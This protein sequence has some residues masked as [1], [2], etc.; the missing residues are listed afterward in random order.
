MMSLK[1]SVLLGAAAVA[2]VVGASRTQAFA[3][4]RDTRAQQ[5]WNGEW[6]AGIQQEPI[7][8]TVSGDAVVVAAYMALWVIL[9][10]YVL[11]LS[12]QLRAIRRDT[13]ELK[14]RIGEGG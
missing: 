5:A 11:R 3:E 7:R 9:L 4:P 2:C 8:E 12:M 14:R 1:K 10:L 6:T 13:D